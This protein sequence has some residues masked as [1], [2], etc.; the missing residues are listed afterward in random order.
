MI[1][2]D[3]SVGGHLARYSQCTRSYLVD[4]GLFKNAVESCNYEGVTDYLLSHNR[5]HSSAVQ[6]YIMFQN[7][8]EEFSAS[9]Q[10]DIQNIEAPIKN[11][12]DILIKMPSNDTFMSGGATLFTRKVA[13]LIEFKVSDLVLTKRSLP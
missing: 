2:S 7:Q 8:I 11:L 4:S 13:T 1:V 10:G 3:P 9:I 12:K 6:A 5:I